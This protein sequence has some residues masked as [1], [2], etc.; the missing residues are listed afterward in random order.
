M[1]D[2]LQGRLTQEEV[3]RAL[4]HVWSHGT[5][6]KALPRPPEDPKIPDWLI[7]LGQA[8]GP[9]GSAL[10]W[11]VL[12]VLL[13]IAVVSVARAAYL[14]LE[15]RR[16]EDGPESVL[17][18][19]P[20][21]LGDVG[22]KALSAA[23]AFAAAHRFSEAIHALLL[24]TLEELSARLGQPFARSLTSRE[25]AARVHI[26]PSAQSALAEL[27]RQTELCHFGEQD[28]GPDDYRRCVE[29]HRLF[30]STLRASE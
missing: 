30:L 21:R 5:Y 7:A 23:E 18:N 29:H 22:A 12:L 1:P 11:T 24:L 26:G 8:L 25:I 19:R 16:R 10:G 27:V 20:V 3:A 9:V 15:R 2:V 28:V 13:L 17:E 6:Q 4:G 14:Y